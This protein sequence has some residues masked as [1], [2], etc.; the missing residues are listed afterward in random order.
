MASDNGN[1]FCDIDQPHMD[2]SFAIQYTNTGVQHLL[3][4]Y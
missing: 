3:G 2:P 1:N 4:Q